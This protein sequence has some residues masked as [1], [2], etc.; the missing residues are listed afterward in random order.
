MSI[1]EEYNIGKNMVEM[2]KFIIKTLLLHFQTPHI[3][4]SEEKICWNLTLLSNTLKHLQSNALLMM[5]QVFCEL[6]LYSVIFIYLI[7]TLL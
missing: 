6:D 7:Q 4:L 2:R 1:L 5:I 3:Q